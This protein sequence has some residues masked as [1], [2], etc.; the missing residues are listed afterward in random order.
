MPLRKA[1]CEKGRMA[2]RKKMRK[3]KV[4]NEEASAA[5]GRFKPY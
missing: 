1:T 4:R 2:R 3:D 5:D